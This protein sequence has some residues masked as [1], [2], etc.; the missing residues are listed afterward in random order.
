MKDNCKQ[1]RYQKE[2]PSVILETERTPGKDGI[3]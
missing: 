1:C 3:T 2:Y